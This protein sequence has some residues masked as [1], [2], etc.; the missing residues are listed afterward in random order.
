LLIPE[1]R[2]ALLGQL[3]YERPAVPYGLQALVL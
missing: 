1:V 3:E 2:P